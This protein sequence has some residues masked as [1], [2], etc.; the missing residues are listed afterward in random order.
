MKKV[1]LGK[2]GLMVTPVIYGGIVSMKDGQEASDRYVK[3][4]LERGI[5][6]YDVAPVYEDAQEKL[7]NSLIGKRDEI[8]LACKTTTRTYL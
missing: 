6:Y 7:G 4:S 2:T 3:W 1:Q 5:N 8:Y